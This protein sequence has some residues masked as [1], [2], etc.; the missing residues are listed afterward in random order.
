MVEITLEVPDKLA[1]RLQPMHQWLPTLLELSLIG[2]QT[3]AAQ[4]ASDLIAFLTKGPSPAAIVAYTVPEKH[5]QR[6]RRLLALNEAGMLSPE[7][8]LE[9]DELEQ[10]EH[11]MTLL[12]AKAQELL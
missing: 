3:P 6:L 10:L 2:F 5:Q 11:I 1:Q 8:T 9:L 7:E 12:K 4:T